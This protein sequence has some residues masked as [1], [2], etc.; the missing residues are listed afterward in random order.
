MQT[1]L[2]VVF[3][4]IAE[5]CGPI[6]QAK[7][8]GIACRQFVQLMDKNPS[9]DEFKLICIGSMDHESILLEKSEIR[10][11]NVPEKVIDISLP[12]QDIDHYR[13]NKELKDG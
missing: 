13:S 5:E 3:D 1:N 11:V 8:D 12:V 9:K 2:Y 10:T 7:N 4:K 6:F